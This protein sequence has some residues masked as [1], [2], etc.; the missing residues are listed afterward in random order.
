MLD[1]IRCM[2]YTRCAVLTWHCYF[3]ALQHILFLLGAFNTLQISVIT[4]LPNLPSVHPS[5]CLNMS[6]ASARAVHVNK[7][8]HRDLKEATFVDDHDEDGGLDEVGGR[9][10][11]WSFMIKSVK[12]N[13]K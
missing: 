7:D 9:L 2:D 10:R 3:T 12:L 5:Y 11:R 6:Q 8:T 13:E 4:L 1:N